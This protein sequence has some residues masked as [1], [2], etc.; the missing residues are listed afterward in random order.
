MPRASLRWLF[1]CLLGVAAVAQ[2]Q[3]EATRDVFLPSGKVM[4]VLSVSRLNIAHQG[5]ALVLTY[6]TDLSISNHSA[7]RKEIDEIWPVFKGDVDK[8]RLTTAIITAKET[9]QGVVLKSGGAYYFMFRKVDGEWRMVSDTE[10]SAD[11]TR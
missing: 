3:T 4:R 5:T 1:L 2:A 10:R 8:A 9:P 11:R 7:L 6:Q